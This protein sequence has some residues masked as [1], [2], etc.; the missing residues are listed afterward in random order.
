M[1]RRPLGNTGFSIAPLI[2]G[3]NVFGWTADENMSYRLMDE[4]TDAGF[5]MIDTADTYTVRVPGNTGGDSERLIG[6]WLQ[7]SGKRS[8]VVIATKVGG[9]LSE[10]KKG[11][12]KDYILR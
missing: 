9:T 12:K 10:E 6:K 4:F 8:Q 5:N 2:F 1:E 11:L 7:R 3:G